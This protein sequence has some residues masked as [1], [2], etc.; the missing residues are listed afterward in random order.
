LEEVR[1]GLAARVDPEKAEGMRAYMKSAMPF[2]GVQG[3]GREAV[4]REVFAARLLG[5][6]EIWHQTVLALWRE[7]AHREERYLAIAL[8]G[9]R[10]YRAFR[11]IDALPIWEELIV[12]GA[13]W[14]FVDPV[15]VGFLGELLLLDHAGLAPVLRRWSVDPNMWK[16]RSSIIA[17]VKAKEH[18][19][20]E[21]L[22]ACIEPNR[23]DREFFIRKAI[24]WALRSYAW[25]DPA[26]VARYVEGH[27]LTALS[28]REALK[29]A[30]KTRATARPGRS[31][32]TP[33]T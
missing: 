20:L 18:T 11:T 1:R 12:D 15:A 7:A 16:R 28:R 32:R 26:E 14:D 9:D 6:R 24:G 29:N 22:Y 25:I 13:W 21:L 27:E 4:A 30:G 33:R 23:G 2:Y 8:A 3:P 31:P 10:R 5:D 19:D 17:Q